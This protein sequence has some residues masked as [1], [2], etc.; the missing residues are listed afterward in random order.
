MDGSVGLQFYNKR[1]SPES[2]GLTRE[3]GTVSVKPAY[4][5]KVLQQ[6]LA[7][8]HQIGAAWRNLAVGSQAIYYLWQVLRKVELAALGEIPS[9]AAIS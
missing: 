9:L 6:A 7:H 5:R 2:M 8:F 1:R 3:S 4:F